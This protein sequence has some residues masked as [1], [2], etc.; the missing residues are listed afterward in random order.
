MNINDLIKQNTRVI[1]QPEII[2]TFLNYDRRGNL[3]LR[4]HQLELSFEDKDKTIQLSLSFLQIDLNKLNSISDYVIKIF[5]PIIDHLNDHFNNYIFKIEVNIEIKQIT[6]SRLFLVSL[7]ENAEPLSQDYI[8]DIKSYIRAVF[9]EIQSTISK[10]NET[11][12]KNDI[13]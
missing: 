3:T 1:F 13:R 10:I 5:K 6:D 2:N 9:T 4:N 12:P 8:S 11:I 7:K